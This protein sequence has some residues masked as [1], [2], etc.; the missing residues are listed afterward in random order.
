[1]ALID[2]KQFADRVYEAS[3]AA[4]SSRQHGPDLLRLRAVHR[5]L[6]PVHAPGRQHRG[7]TDSDGS[8]IPRDGGP[9]VRD[10]LDAD[11]EAVV[12]WRLGVFPY[13]G[14]DHFGEVNRLFNKNFGKMVADDAFDGGLDALPCR[15]SPASGD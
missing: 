3:K 12:I 13:E 14:G 8:P 15:R 9:E 7:G 1:M 2:P 11:W 10:D 5:R 6:T 4:F